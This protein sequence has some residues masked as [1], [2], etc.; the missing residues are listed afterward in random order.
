MIDSTSSNNI[1]NIKCDQ[2][3]VISYCTDALLRSSTL[4]YGKIQTDTWN[5]SELSWFKVE[6][7]SWL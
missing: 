5:E 2:N 7:P 6:I 4:S 1:F 3:E